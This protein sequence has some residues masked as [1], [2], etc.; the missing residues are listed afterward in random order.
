MAL[1]SFTLFAANAVVLALMALAFHFAGRR[2]PDQA[3]WRSWCAANL[4]LAAAL[5]FFM[6]PARLPETLSM[7]VPNG[8]LLAGFG[9]RWRAAREFSGRGST[10]HS[11]WAPTILFLVLCA[12]PPVAGSYAIIYSVV[13]I[14]LATLAGAVAWEFR[15]D[16]DDQLPSRYGLIAAYALLSLSFAAR[17][18]QGFFVGD[19]FDAY[20]P[21]DAMLTVHLVIA[22]LHTPASGAFAL[23]IA[24]ERTT[25]K[26][27]HAAAH[28][29]LTELLNRGAFE[30]MVA[31]RMSRD[32]AAAQ[33][34]LLLDIDRFKRINDRHGHAAGD[35]ILRACARI[36]EDEAGRNTLV[37][38]IGG[39]EFAVH[40]H[41]ATAPEAERTAERIRAAVQSARITAGDNTL[42]M[43]VSV[44][45]FWNE[46]AG[47]D[48]EDMLRRAD[49]ALYRAKETGRN[50]VERLAA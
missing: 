6:F 20:L 35:A 23:S 5:V 34:V 46:G 19:A 27:R 11:I 49:V 42:A 33:A 14:L 9:L 2:N 37:A 40:I 50:R 43:T 10:V 28:D 26:L 24:Y 36:V 41:N 45:W 18:V 39:E 22:L 44:G 48:L 16:R 12:I 8:L 30:R 1:D 21:Y 13:N 3:Y 31:A 7:I 15:R 38:R 29:S 47:L 4:L 17:V 32:N 25:A